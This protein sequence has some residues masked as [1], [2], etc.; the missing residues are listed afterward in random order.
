MVGRG[1]RSQTMFAHAW[2]I[3]YEWWAITASSAVND[4]FQVIKQRIRGDKKETKQKKGIMFPLR[5]S[6]VFVYEPLFKVYM[7]GV[8]LELNYL[9]KVYNLEPCPHDLI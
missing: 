6:T 7:P 4:Y 3:T 2:R 1:L 8:L 5:S 9:W